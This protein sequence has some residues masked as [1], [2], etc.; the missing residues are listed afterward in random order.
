MVEQVQGVVYM[1]K[2][3]DLE[4]YRKIATDYIEKLIE[5]GIP[6]SEAYIFG[7]YVNGNKHRWSDLDTCIV[8]TA[9]GVDPI[10]E[11]VVLMMIG[12]KINDLIEPHPFSPTDFN[13][14][15]NP[16]ANEIRKH[17]SR[18]M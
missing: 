1:D 18:I 9:F 14:K 11:R 10:A 3:T 12:R 15:Y 5:I 8:S 2:N 17:G 7:S 16:L 6:V 13:N 4:K